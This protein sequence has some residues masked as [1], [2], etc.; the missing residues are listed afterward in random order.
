MA[1]LFGKKQ[2]LTPELI[3]EYF[4]KRAAEFKKLVD[5]ASEQAKKLSS[6]TAKVERDLKK[7]TSS[8]IKSANSK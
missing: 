1:P 8:K 3:G 4:D 7:P 6:K 5:K 2:E